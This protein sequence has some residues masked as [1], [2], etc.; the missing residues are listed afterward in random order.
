MVSFR[1]I[2]RNFDRNLELIEK[3]TNI[4]IATE[5]D[6]KKIKGMLEKVNQT[7]DN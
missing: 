2:E 7:Q 1:Q 6:I 4:E 3:M 5:D